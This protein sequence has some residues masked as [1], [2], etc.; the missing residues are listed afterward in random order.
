MADM[1]KFEV[2]EQMREFAD[3]SVD[4]ARKAFDSFLSASTQAI[5]GLEDN[6]SKAQSAG[7]D[8]QKDVLSFAENQVNRA[9]DLAQKMV[10]AKDVNELVSLQRSYAEEQ[11][12]LVSDSAKQMGEKMSEVAKDV[13]SGFKS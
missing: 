9:F 8:I 11:M 3:K 6:A 12:K 7:A 2:P 13:T 5:S 10:R 4:Q 1:P